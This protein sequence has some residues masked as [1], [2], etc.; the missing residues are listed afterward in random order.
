MILTVIVIQQ[1]KNYDMYYV[2]FVVIKKSRGTHSG[3]S[4]LSVNFIVKKMLLHLIVNIVIIIYSTSVLK[5]KI[6]NEQT[7]HD[8]TKN[9]CLL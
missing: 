4:L 5:T 8:F 9:L 1:A 6:A 2:L 3:R 7:I